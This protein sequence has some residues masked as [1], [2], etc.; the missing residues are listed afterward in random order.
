MS[1]M[2]RE[3]CYG[4][5]FEE[6]ES[7]SAITVATAGTYY[8]WITAETGPG[9]GSKGCITTSTGDPS[10]LT[11]ATGGAGGY[12]IMWHAGVDIEG[13][14][15]AHG[16]I[17]KNGS[18]ILPT[19]NH[20]QSDS[21]GKLNLAMSGSTMTQLVAGDVLTLQFTSDSN[22]DDVDIFHASLTAIRID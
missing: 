18:R 14:A 13:G 9:T 10:S 22:S 3:P 8:P 2:L 11:I 12:L 15:I 19:T 6:N 16:A 4:K 7:G 1:G 20:V 5:I 21:A 17:F